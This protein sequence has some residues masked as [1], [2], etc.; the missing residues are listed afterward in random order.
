MSK[1][2]EKAAKEALDLTQN[3]YSNGAINI[4]Q[5]IDAQNNYL[6]AQF[7]KANA[8]NNYLIKSLQL[9]R[10]LGYYFLLNSF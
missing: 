6:N 2:S 8:V 7:I 4:V 1:V 3:A 9:E 5:L 10:Y